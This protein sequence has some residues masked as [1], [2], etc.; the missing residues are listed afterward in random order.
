LT[1]SL[2][3]AHSEYSLLDG[4]GNP[5]DNAKRASD[6]G[7]KALSISDHGVCSAHLLH[8]KA[9][10]KNNI[11]PVLGNELYVAH[12]HAFVKSATNR[13][14]SHMVVWA[15]NKQGWYDLIKMTSHTNNPKYYYYKPRLSLWNAT[16]EDGTPYLGLE[17]FGAKGNL[18]GFSGHQGSHLSDNLFCDLYGDPEERKVDLKTAYFQYKDVDFEY[19]RRFLKEDWLESTCEL[20]LK[21]EQIFGKGNFFVELQNELKESD[22]LALHIHP[23]K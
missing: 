3:H 21:L 14:N 15:K 13:S 10:K 2:F 12:D 20:A 5:K 18:M 4:H 17:H 19:Y 6:L 22:T 23:I 1:Y 9:C 16:E 11:K 7:L 8:L